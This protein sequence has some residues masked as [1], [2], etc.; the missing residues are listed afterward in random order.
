[1]TTRVYRR[2]P[3]PGGFHTN[4][5]G[6][7]RVERRAP[8]PLEKS[9]SRAGVWSAMI[10][11]V[12]LTL[13]V[14]LTAIM[15]SDNQIRGGEGEP[16]GGAVVFG[17]PIGG[18]FTIT[19]H[20]ANDR[21]QWNAT[22]NQWQGFRAMNLQAELG[23]PILATYAGTITEV[24]RSQTTGTLIRI[25]HAHGLE[26]VL[27]GLAPEVDVRRGDTVRKGQQIGT[28]GDTLALEA[29]DGPTLRIQIYQNGV[30]VNPAD[31][32]AFGDNK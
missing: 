25:Q 10:V 2:T 15:L 26:T 19:R 31:F 9:K 28:F 29:L 30:R 11:M 22:A 24:S 20:Y 21:L 4:S 27:S 3:R 14:A 13:T 6:E 5:W 12:M 1:M 18:E 8:E 16:V 17:V 23:T 32:I 7:P